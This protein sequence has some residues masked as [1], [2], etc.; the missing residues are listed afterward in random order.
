MQARDTV[1]TLVLALGAV[2]PASDAA[3]SVAD[4]LFE[5]L[6]RER[7]AAGVPAWE[8]RA[9]LDRVALEAATEVAAVRGRSLTRPIEAILDSLEVRGVY[10]AV[11]VVQVLLGYAEPDEIAVRRFKQYERVWDEILNPEIDA[12]G[13]AEAYAED[14][15]LVV[16]GVLVQDMEPV[17]LERLEREIAEGVNAVRAEND[18]PPLASLEP[19]AE[20]ARAHSADMAAR[21]YFDHRSPE[22]AGAA[23]R[24]F[25]AS[26]VFT[27]VAE[28][29][30]KIEGGD[31]PAAMAIESWMTSPAHRANILSREYAESGV[32]AAVDDR[33]A[34]YIT[35][36]FTQ[37][38]HLPRRGGR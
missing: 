6:D 2:A 14:G 11:P 36:V 3:P 34:V 25:S 4:G 30:S 20:V 32:G 22:G 15:S 13:I 19:L 38:A 16:V 7:A 12:I 5:R 35:Q 31:D 24:L 23:S 33:G 9:V 29:I 1:L 10:R 21:R 37:D 26:I 18:L 27:R 8:R 17:D 28:N